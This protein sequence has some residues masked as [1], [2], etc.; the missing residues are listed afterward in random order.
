VAGERSDEPVTQEEFLKFRRAVVKKLKFLEGL[1]DD[2]FQK[3]NDNDDR[4]TQ[5][6]DEAVDQATRAMRAVR[7]LKKEYDEH[8]HE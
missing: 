8:E 7:R 3:I 6:V 2:S 1:I 5:V 4:T